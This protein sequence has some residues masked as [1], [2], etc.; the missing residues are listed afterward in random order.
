MRADECK[1]IVE[2]EF[3]AFRITSIAV[4]EF[5]GFQSAL[6]DNHA[7]RD[8]QQLCI[9]EFDPR[10]G[11]AI[12]VQHLDTGGSELRIEPIGDLAHPCG[13]LR[14]YGHQY[15]LEW[16]DRFRPDDAPLIVI[17]LD[18]GSH[19]ARHT[20]AVAAHV[21]R[22]FLAAF[23][24]YHTLHGLAVFLPELEDVTDF[25]APGDL[26]APVPGGAGIALDH[27]P[28]VGR[29]H[30]L[31]IPVPVRPGEMHV[32]FVR[33]ADEVRQ[34]QGAVIHVHTA[35]ETDRANET[36]LGAAG[37]RDAFCARH[38]QGTGYPW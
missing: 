21:Q 2:R 10:A 18:G 4:F 6:T 29:D 14:A 30:S 35:A 19:D 11:V 25:D 26:Q 12:V 38:M 28:D 5:A 17:L 36:H 34:R 23:I 31:H 33:A 7:V 24:E 32:L 16:C 15:D 9:R 13:L 27:V 3:L 8:T 37:A 20:D 1:R 22:H